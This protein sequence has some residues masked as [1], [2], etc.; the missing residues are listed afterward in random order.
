MLSNVSATTSC[1]T[2]QLLQQTKPPA[3]YHAPETLL[4]SAEQG[5]DF[6]SILPT[7]LPRSTNHLRSRPLAC[8]QAGST[9]DVSKTT[10]P[11]LKMP[12]SSYPP[13][14]TCFG[15][16]LATLQRLVSN[17]A[18]PL[19]TMLQVWNT[20]LNASAVM[21]QTSLW[22]PNQVLTPAPIRCNTILVA[23]PLH[24]LPTLSATRF[25]PA[26]DPIFAD[27]ETC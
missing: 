27:Q 8:Q 16:T 12:K 5:T 4:R 24:L 19:V 3:T 17:N 20:A 9:R 15:T 11:P 21:S 2:V 14:L 18:R 23:R 26:M 6:L 7:E 25:V 1:T 13:S 10:S 22:L